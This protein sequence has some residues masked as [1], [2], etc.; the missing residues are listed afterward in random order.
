MNAR[1]SINLTRGTISKWVV[2]RGG[3]YIYIRIAMLM[4]STT[5]GVLTAYSESFRLCD[6]VEGLCVKFET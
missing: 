1:L 3:E 4:R 2:L 6:K 5:E